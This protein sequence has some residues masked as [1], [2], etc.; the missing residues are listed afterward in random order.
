FWNQGGI[1]KGSYHTIANV[2]DTCMGFR[3][4]RLH[5]Y[6][7]S[8]EVI[9][10]FKDE[11]GEFFSFADK[12]HR[13]AEDMLS[14]YKCSQIAFPGETIMKE[15]E[16]VLKYG[17]HR[18]LPRLET[19]FYIEHLGIAN[20]AWSTKTTYRFSCITFIELAKLDFNVV[21]TIHQKELQH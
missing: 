10:N 9:K 4:L 6:S 1:R 18:S 5:G 21:Q 16:Y 15:V 13:E 2:N 20:D 19:R 7:V 14:L 8:S 11:K 12:T 17:F 3:I